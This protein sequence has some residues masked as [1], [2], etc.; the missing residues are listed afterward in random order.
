MS[1]LRHTLRLLLK[2]PGFTIT[3][4]LIL[5]FGI[6]TNTAVFSLIS[7]VL[8]NPLPFPQADRL[9]QIFQSRTTISVLDRSDWGGVSYPDYLDLRDSQ[10]TLDNIAVEYWDYLDLGT[11]QLPQRLTAIYASPS[12]FKVSNLPFVL[13][14]PFIDAEDKTGGPLVAVLSEALWRDHFNADPHVIGQNIILSGESFQVVG[15]CPRQVED[16]ST[17]SDD[18]IYVP[19]HVSEYFGGPWTNK[20]DSHS[21][22]CF[23]RLQQAATSVQA[24]A[25]LNVIQSNLDARY[26]DA[27]KNYII[28]VAS[29]FDS[30]AATYS[31]TV[32]LLGGAVGCLLL[33]SCANVAN[34]IFARGLERRKEMTIRSTLGASR[35]RLVKQLLLETTFLSVLGGVTGSIIA[36]WSIGLIKWLSPDYLNRFQDV[37]LDSASLL[38]I[39]LIT[40]FVTLLSGL[41]PGLSLSKTNLETVLREEGNRGGTTGLHRQRT[42]SILVTG[43][44]AAACVLLIGAGLLVR[45]FQ[46]FQEIPLGFNAGHLVSANI[47]PTSKKYNDMPQMRRLFAAV[48]EKAKEL[49]GVTDAALNQEQP[50]EW[51][52]GDLN[53]PFHIP[54]QPV[55]EP[56]KEPTLCSQ[57]I[58]PDYF[59]TMQIPI[60]AGRDF[61]ADDRAD[62]QHVVIVDVALAQRFF[63]G[64]DP[65]GKQIEDLWATRDDQKTWTIVGVVGQVRHNAPDHSLAP[66]QAY[67][68]YSQRDNLFRAFLLLRTDR[69]PAALAPAIQKIVAS[70][71]PD[72]PADRIQKFDD[73]IAGRSATRRFSAFLVSIISGAALCLSAVGLYGV[74]AYSVSQRR[75]ELGVRIALGAQ[76]S[77]V[78]RLV[79][80]KGLT[81]AGLG[82]AI[83]L[84][85]ALLLVR[86]FESALYK[87]SASDPLALSLAVFVLGIATVL[88]CLLPALRAVRINPINA[89][90]E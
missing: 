7:T 11:R 76:S 35:F 36:F 69:E 60:V 14:R 30:T 74:L 1:A 12:L 81:L 26:P 55:T 65:I 43:Q 3:A 53:A 86:C 84:M 50:F 24:N 5:G 90:R 17:P 42:Q 88:A 31:A 73:V 83:G 32:W 78:L 45:S 80:L 44:V 46:V 54:G 23:G 48:L 47:N 29:L 38:F 63:P 89:L 4:V 71:D 20:R 18:A 10:K 34:L 56:G 68:P 57:D 75:R 49:P 51:T 33:I 6:G 15:V 37:H 13:G 39:F 67:F 70:I 27:N 66:Y 62:S 19:I 64:G 52:F 28:R 41:L 59:K 82:L 25:D 77:N 21:L 58:S 8:L 40:A 16:V 79:V 72:V 87:V 22:L 61:D 9:V 85:S 2:S